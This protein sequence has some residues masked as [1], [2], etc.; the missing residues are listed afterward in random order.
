M[1]LYRDKYLHNY[2]YILET[3][4]LAF[5]QTMMAQMKFSIMLHFIRACTICSYEG[6]KDMIIRKFLLVTLKINNDNHILILCI[7]RE[8]PSDK[9]TTFLMDRSKS[10][11]ILWIIFCYLCWFLL[12]CDVCFSQPCD[13]LIGKG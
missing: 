6:M 13:H 7:C 2:I 12:Y 8:N 9:N 10:E 1:L 3:L 11:L 5:W 4:K